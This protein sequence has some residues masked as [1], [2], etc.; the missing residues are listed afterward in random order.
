MNS[1]VDVL[2]N[3]A[4][5]LDVVSAVGVLYDVLII[6]AARDRGFT[7]THYPIS[8]GVD[9]GSLDLKDTGEFLSDLAQDDTWFASATGIFAA[10]A[11]MTDKELTERLLS[12]GIDFVPPKKN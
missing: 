6:M 12:M 7:I 2:N 1:I 11:G 3:V 4:Q 10:L 5:Q 8:D 9:A